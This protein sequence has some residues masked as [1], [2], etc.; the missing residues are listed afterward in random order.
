MDDFKFPSESLPF[1]ANPNPS[2][3]PAALIERERRE[4]ITAG[5]VPEDLNR[6]LRRRTNEALRAFWCD[7][8]VV[9][10]SAV[11]QCSPGNPLQAEYDR[12]AEANRN[13]VAED[14]RTR[15]LL[16]SRKRSRAAASQGSHA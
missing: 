11:V 4:I 15:A 5:V 14:A 7:M 1:S 3:L 9:C 8:Q 10:D 2:L 12:Q 16:E 6:V 13:R